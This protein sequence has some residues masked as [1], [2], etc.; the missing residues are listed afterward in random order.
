MVDLYSI[1]CVN[2]YGQYMDSLNLDLQ[3]FQTNK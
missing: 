2:K 3:F 1:L